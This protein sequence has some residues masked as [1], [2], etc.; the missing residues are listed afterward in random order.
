MIMENKFFLLLGTLKRK[1]L[2]PLTQKGLT[3]LMNENP[4]NTISLILEGIHD[5]ITKESLDKFCNIEQELDK[6]EKCF[7][8]LKKYRIYI[9]ATIQNRI[10]EIKSESSN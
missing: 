1:I 7:P 9:K 5:K 6:I 4:D 10:E 3:R 2:R 8:E